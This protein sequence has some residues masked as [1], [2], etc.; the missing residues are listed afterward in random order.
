MLGFLRSLRDGLKDLF[1]VLSPCRYSV[2]ILLVGA[3]SFLV[4]PQ[5]QDVLR[6]LAEWNSSRESFL[7]VYG[8]IALFVVATLVWAAS[9]WYWA[10]VILY[11][12]PP[13][14][15]SQAGLG[16]WVPRVMGFLALLSMSAALWVASTNYVKYASD[17]GALTGGEPIMR[18][19]LLSVTLLGFALAFLAFVTKRRDILRVARARRA[20]QPPAEEGFVTAYQ[21]FPDRGRLPAG[22]KRAAVG[23]LVASLVLG[24]LFAIAP[25]LCGQT[26]GTLPVVLLSAA[27]GVLFGTGLLYLSR[28]TRFPLLLLLVAAAVMFSRCNDNH[29]MRLVSGPLP[30]R[31]TIQKQFQAWSR[32]KDPRKPIFIVAAEGGGIRAAYWTAIALGKLE[33]D[34]PGFARQ[35]FA[36]SGVSGGSLG[37]AVFTALVAE[38]EGGNDLSSCGGVR[39]CAAEVLGADFL[40][41]VVARMVAPDLI[42]RLWFHPLPFTDRA[43]ALEDGWADAW[44]DVVSGEGPNRFDQGFLE[45]WEGKAAS[46]VPSLVLNGTHVESGRRIAAANLT[47][48]HDELRDAY[49]LLQ[50]AGSDLPLKTAVHASA[51]FTYVSPAGTMRPDDAPRGAVVGA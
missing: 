51:R 41:P 46:L 2:L 21:D 8:R 14:S 24:L 34:N 26:L 49:D 15:S 17:D 25:V 40:S 50:V 47:W 22:T 29:A 35:V 23:S 38:K 33:D 4:V 42:Q 31:P 45:L 9:T 44:R 11:L 43:E 30:E 28:Q 16:E 18:L 32:D 37:G 1:M 12:S 39:A 13:E 19:H 10:R 20:G 6:R 7:E 36:I 48:N 3:V 27:N 5:G